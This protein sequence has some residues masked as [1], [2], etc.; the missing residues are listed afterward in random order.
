MIQDRSVREVLA[1]ESVSPDHEPKEEETNVPKY[2]VGHAFRQKSPWREGWQPAQLRVKRARAIGNINS[3]EFDQMKQG[4]QKLPAEANRCQN[5]VS[6]R[7]K[8]FRIN[9]VACGRRGWRR[10]WKYV[11]SGVKFF[12]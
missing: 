6:A 5:C 11:I 3:E 2:S 9:V 7:R 10:A 1:K 12:S 8:C 4:Q